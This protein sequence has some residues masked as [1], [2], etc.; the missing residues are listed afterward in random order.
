V[1][2]CSVLIDEFNCCFY[3]RISLVS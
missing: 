1:N 2:S 3:P